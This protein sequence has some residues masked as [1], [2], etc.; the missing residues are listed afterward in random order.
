MVYVEIHGAQELDGSRGVDLSLLRKALGDTKATGS[1]I[2]RAPKLGYRFLPAVTSIW[3]RAA[4]AATSAWVEEA[5]AERVMRFIAMPFRLVH[6]DE[7]IDF[8]GRSLPGGD[9]GVAGRAALDDGTFQPAGRAVCRG[10]AGSQAYRAGK[11]GSRAFWMPCCGARRKQ[12]RHSLPPTETGCCPNT[13]WGH[14]SLHGYA[15]GTPRRHRLRPAG[16]T[17]ACFPGSR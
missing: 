1:Y 7:R 2:Q 5:P 4:A 17:G 16:S 9:R 11:G 15:T 13:E 10:S 6:G 14:G 8:L 3:G 12:G